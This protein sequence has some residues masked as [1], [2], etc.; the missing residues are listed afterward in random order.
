MRKETQKSIEN[1][2]F[3]F[4]TLFPDGDI[5][6]FKEI[7]EKTN[8]GTLTYREAQVAKLYTNGSL[9]IKALTNA[10]SAAYKALQKSN[11]GVIEKAERF[12]G[13][14]GNAKSPQLMSGIRSDITVLTNKIKDALDT[15]FSEIQ[16]SVSGGSKALKTLIKPISVFDEVIKK[17]KAGRS[18]E[19]MEVGGT[20][21]FQSIPDEQAL[22]ELLGGIKNIPDDEV[23]QA[24]YLALL[25]YRGTALQGISSSFEAATEG[26]DVF[27]YFDPQTEQIVRPDVRKPGKKPLP[28]TSKPGPVAVD[29]LK[30][31]AANASEF[32][33]LFPNVTRD[34]IAT[35]LNEH[36]YP[37]LSKSTVDKL[38]RMPSGYTDMRRFFASAIA[39]LLGDAKQASVLIG[40][41]AG[42]ESLE[43]EFD[44]VLTNHYARLTKAAAKAEDVRHK[45]LFAYESILAR[46]LG[47]STSNDL[48]QFL[49]LPFEE[50]VTARYST[51]DIDIL[52]G[53]TTAPPV[54]EKTPETPQE[55]EARSR[56][57]VA[58]DNQ[59]AAETELA[60]IQTQKQIQAETKELAAGA[61]EYLAGVKTQA[62]ID[63]QAAEVK[64][65]AKAEAKVASKV[66]K[67]ASSVASMI[68]EFGTKAGK[69]LLP[70]AMFEGARMGY[71]ATTGMP[72]P[73][74]ALGA[75]AGAAAE[76]I[77]PP[78]MAPTDVEFRQSQRATRPSGTGLG[79]R[80]DIADQ[81]SALGYIRPEQAQYPMEAAPVSI[82]DVAPVRPAALSAGNAKERV[83]L[84]TKAAEQGKETTLSGFL[85]LP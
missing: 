85:N 66:K 4:D 84:A 34:V 51:N 23:R 79:P 36:V 13:V 17:V 55:A 75:T 18:V 53:D 76:V 37:N 77:A 24:T 64:A 20:R 30:F 63:A 39:N 2:E 40:H 29:T 70:L 35:A 42:A 7:Q 68:A 57:N 28:P 9:P 21:I 25:G 73:V 6:S 27:P 62:A 11:P 32:G 65:Q 31:R 56:K 15:P 69:A 38:G 71:E 43:A 33:E 52:T 59:I 67:G 22:K 61:D 78:G 49:N 60:N 58:L 81:M 54:T 10:D 82:P 46:V 45:T 72:A 26:E 83:N 3:V 16:V 50:G 41:T 14:F 44:K 5:P 80:T 48:A 19:G 12:Y 8:A 1:F 47:K 74:R